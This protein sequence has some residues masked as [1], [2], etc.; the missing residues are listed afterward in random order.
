MIFYCGQEKRFYFYFY[1]YDIFNLPKIYRA[2]LMLGT[3]IGVY[4]IFL[5]CVQSREFACS[6]FKLLFALMNFY[7]KRIVH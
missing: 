7:H 5:E 2:R 6:K 3:L 4:N 1:F